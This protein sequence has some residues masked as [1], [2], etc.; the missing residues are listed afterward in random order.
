MVHRLDERPRRIRAGSLMTFAFLLACAS[1]LRPWV[2]QWVGSMAPLDQAAHRALSIDP[3]NGRF[4]AVLATT[5]HYSLLR[6][7]YPTALTHY[8]ATLQSNPLD[9]ATWLHLGKLYQQLNRSR[10]SDHSLRL[11]VQLAPTDPMILWEA[12]LAYLQEGRV[13]DA[14]RTLT[15]FIAVSRDEHDRAKGNDLARRLGPPEGG[16]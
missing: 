4:H 3:G 16:A 6:R 14:R 11:A 15:R 10:E 12:T 13:P 7:D 5:Y 9:A 1:A 8:Q 2:A